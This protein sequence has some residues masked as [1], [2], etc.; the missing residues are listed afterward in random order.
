LTRA[1]TG[2]TAAMMDIRIADLRLPVADLLLIAD[3][4]GAARFV[5]S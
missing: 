2:I 3:F 4:V 5:R 1:G